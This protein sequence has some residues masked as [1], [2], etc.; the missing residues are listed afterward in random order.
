MAAHSVPNTYQ[1]EIATAANTAEGCTSHFYYCQG[2]AA[3]QRTLL[4]QM[5]E[6]GPKSAI[7]Q[8]NIYRETIR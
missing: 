1:P 3:L 4:G 6:T 7:F 5:P 2:A 8:S